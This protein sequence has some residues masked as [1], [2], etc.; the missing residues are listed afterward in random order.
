MTKTAIVI[1]A[2]G[3]VGKELV[4]LLLADA[5]YQKVI[6][7]HRR[8]TNLTHPK[9]EEHIINFEDP[10]SYAHL[11]KG[12]VLFSS[13]GTTIKQAGSQEAQYRI[14]YTYQ[15]EPAEIAAKNGVANY[16]LVSS[17]GANAKSKLFYPRMKGELEEAIKKL[18]FKKIDIIQPSLLLGDRPEKRFG[19][20]FGAILLKG[21]QHIPRLKKYRGIH[22]Y[23]VA[24][25]MINATGKDT[26]DK[27]STYELEGVFDL[28]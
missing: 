2:T 16:V 21:L 26:T 23:E 9:L 4:K 13:L 7:L 3:L 28:I 1:G 10:N 22:G 18:P 15:Y 20:Q 12:D 11:I 6:I 19:E 24:Q 14:D 25:A 8:S 17:S 27:I 5:T